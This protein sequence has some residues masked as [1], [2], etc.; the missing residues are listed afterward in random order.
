MTRRVFLVAALSLVVVAGAVSAQPAGTVALDPSASC[1]GGRLVLSISGVSGGAG[2]CRESGRATNNG[3]V[4]DSFEQSSG[5]CPTY[6]GGYGYPFAAQPA[7]SIITL[8]GTIGSTPPTPATTI[9]FQL[10]YNCST[11]EVLSSAIG[12]Y[13]TITEAIP[14]LSRTGM[15]VAAGLML[16]AGVAV[17]LYR[18]VG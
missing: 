7:G 16:L 3:V 18:R 8:Y 9:E 6:N 5:A 12:P 17:L 4:I 10:T 1:N 2:G 14:M 11:L 13:G 15:L